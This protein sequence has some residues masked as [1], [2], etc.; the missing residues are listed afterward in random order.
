MY[1]IRL[2]GDLVCLVMFGFARLSGTHSFDRLVSSMLPLA[3]YV[4]VD[5]S[6]FPLA[7]LFSLLVT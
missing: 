7:V 3:R 4:D 5:D 6:D 2:C 1:H